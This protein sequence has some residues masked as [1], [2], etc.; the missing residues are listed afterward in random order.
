MEWWEI[1]SFN[2][3]VI[4]KI[5][6]AF[7]PLPGPEKMKSSSEHRKHA[8]FHPKRHVVLGDRSQQSLL[9]S[10]E[11]SSHLSPLGL[12]LEALPWGVSGR[13]C[14]WPFVHFKKREREAAQSF[15]GRPSFLS[16]EKPL[17]VGDLLPMVDGE[18]EQSEKGCPHFRWRRRWK[19]C[20]DEAVRPSP[21]SPIQAHVEGWCVHLDSE[22][23]QEGQ[24]VSRV[25]IE[26]AES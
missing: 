24:L 5:S 22:E 7:L 25:C 15:L 8:R 2:N 13:H 6:R 9:L 20:A 16:A 11:N 4:R 18:A 14:Y 26:E 12:G 21:L 19:V 3:A 10:P 17:L 1:E 23:G